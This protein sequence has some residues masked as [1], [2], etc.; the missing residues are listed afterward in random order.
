MLAIPNTEIVNSTVASYTN[1][2]HLR[3]E[4]DITLAVREDL[5][6]A[7]RAL[8]ELLHRDERFMRKPEPEMVVKALNDYNVA[9]Q[10]RVWLKDERT[11][12][13]VRFELRERA[14]EALRTAGVDMPFET[15]QIEPLK[16]LSA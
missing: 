11:H 10:F 1:F 8:L 2:P 6:K 5:G 15:L 13:P 16:V 12:I 9:V 7:R 14:F 3:L 4:I